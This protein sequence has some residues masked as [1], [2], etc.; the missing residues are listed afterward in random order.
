MFIP[1]NGPFMIAVDFACL[2]YGC[3]LVQL[4]R[5]FNSH[6]YRDKWLKYMAVALT[7]ISGMTIGF[8]IAS[9]YKV[10]VLNRG[11]PGIWSSSPWEFLLT[12]ITTGLSAFLVQ[13]FF[14][15]RIA[16]FRRDAVGKTLSAIV[17]LVATLAFAGAIADMVVFV[18]NGSNAL[19]LANMFT[20]ARIWTVSSVVCDILIA[21]TMTFLLVS[22]RKQTH[23][24][25]TRD[26]IRRL[27]FQSIETGTVTAI[28]MILML[29]CYETMSTV[30]SSYTVWE[31]AIGPL[32]GNV[33]LF[34]LNARES[35][36]SDEV[37]CNTSDPELPDSSRSCGADFS[38]DRADDVHPSVSGGLRGPE[39]PMFCAAEAISWPYGLGTGVRVLHPHIEPSGFG[40]DVDQHLCCFTAVSSGNQKRSRYYIGHSLFLHSR[41]ATPGASLWTMT[42]VA[43]PADVAEM[44]VPVNGPFLISV[45]LSCLLYGCYLV[46][47]CTY[48]SYHSQADKW[49][50]YLALFI[51]VDSGTTIGF[52]IASQYIILVKNAGNPDIWIANP[53]TTLTIPVTT[54]I[55]AFSVQLFFA[56]RIAFFRRDLVGKGIAAIVSLV[57]L[58]AFAGALADMAV[59]AANG[60]NTLELIDMHSV[61]RIWTVSSVI[62]DALIAG[63]MTVLLVQSRKQTQ[64]RSTQELLR[65]LILLSIES[66]TVTAVAMVLMLICYE[67]MGT[68]NSVYMVWELSIGPLYGNVLLFVLNSR[69]NMVPGEVHCTSG[70]MQ[71][72][73]THFS[74]AMINTGTRDDRLS[75]VACDA[76]YRRAVPRDIKSVLPK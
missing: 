48:L 2:L 1:V 5:Y 3:Y 39:R 53:W 51:T 56:F 54:G 46:Q 58:L 43:T 24:R 29:T 35:M 75:E 55:S 19:L 23:F 52:A 50:K 22:S 70:D 4:G 15:S 25:S 72:S 34:V 66:G 14:A 68:V 62:C 12:P 61:V 49:L 41:Q 20:V 74:V 59:Y 67:T 27:I 65:R 45:D 40:N 13:L 44:F 28:V 57:A 11:N 32:Y 73:A 9:Q 30:N 7:I 26:M 33:M 42:P 36:S 6:S 10:L 31:L 71:L 16:S 63:T 37:L 69:G 21:G 76:D 64:Y 47:L 17:S 38:T 18:K 8:G 60:S